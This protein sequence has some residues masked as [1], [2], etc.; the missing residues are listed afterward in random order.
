MGTES[1]AKTLDDSF[2]A[3][4]KDWDVRTEQWAKSTKQKGAAN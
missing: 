2:F 3:W 1:A 4:Q